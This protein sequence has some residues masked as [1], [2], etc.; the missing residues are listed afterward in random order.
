[1]ISIDHLPGVTGPAF[2]QYSFVVSHDANGLHVTAANG[3][4]R[5][6][7]LA[8]PDLKIERMSS[9]WLHL[10]SPSTGQDWVLHLNATALQL[11]QLPAHGFSRR[12]APRPLQPKEKAQ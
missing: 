5:T 6:L 10:L 8:A 7:P 11:S 1:V 2:Q 4:V 12:L 9:D 3:A